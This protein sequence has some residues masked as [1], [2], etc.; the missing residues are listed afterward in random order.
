MSAPPSPTLS[1][2]ALLD[3]LDDDPRFDLAAQRERRLE[4]LQKEVRKVQVL[5]DSEYGRMITY[6]QEKALIERMSKEKFCLIHFFHP[7]FQRCRIMDQRLEELAP[8]Y[9]HTLFLRAGVA[10]VPFLVAKFGIQ[11]L[12]HVLVF[13]DGR[14][15]DRLIGFEELGDS[16]KFTSKA[17]EFRLQQSGALPTGPISLSNTLSTAV[18]GDADLSDRED[19]EDDRDKA[20]PRR[21][22][23]GIRNGFAS[24]SRDDD[25]DY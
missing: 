6:G 25:E 16:D 21:G 15:A 2:S 18:L 19:S 17:L 5:Q 7:D 20:G 23:T 24:G 13:V 12:P 11:V 9:V 10:D 22:K 4:E 1:D 8:K 3:S 14:C